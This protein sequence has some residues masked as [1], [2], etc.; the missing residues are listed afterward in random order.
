M[1]STDNSKIE[2]QKLIDKIAQSILENERIIKELYSITVTTIPI[3]AKA[4]F[5]SIIYYTERKD[6]C[7]PLTLSIQNSKKKCKAKK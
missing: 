6:V 4:G 7:T 3:N 5:S 2:A 1:G